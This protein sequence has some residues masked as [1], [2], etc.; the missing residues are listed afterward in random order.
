MLFSLTSC[1]QQSSFSTEI[2]HSG[3]KSL[4]LNPSN[5]SYCLQQSSISTR[6]HTLGFENT[7]LIPQILVFIFSR[8]LSWL[9]SN[10]LAASSKMTV[11]RYMD[12][13][14]QPGLNDCGFQ[15]TVREWATWR[16]A[17]RCAKHGGA[18]LKTSNNEVFV[19]LCGLQG[20]WL[21][22]PGR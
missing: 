12:Q 19:E 6:N 21:H 11:S 10:T 15:A 4:W 9:K 17:G 8:A 2:T 16:L 22:W 5:I 3:L 14:C 1:L 13:V 20:F 7:D 18:I